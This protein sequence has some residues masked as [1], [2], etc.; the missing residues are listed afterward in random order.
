MIGKHEAE[1]LKC[2]S[3]EGI[4]DYMKTTLPSSTETD[5][6][7]IC[8]RALDMDIKSQL[9]LFEV[10]YQLLNEEMIDIRQN[11][12]RLEKQEIERKNLTNTIETL[13][14]ELT[15]AKEVIK[16]MKAALDES[17]GRNKELEMRISAV[18]SE[19][20]LLRLSLNDA[21]SET[22]GSQC[23]I[24]SPRSEEV[25][26]ILAHA[27]METSVEKSW[28]LVPSPDTV[29]VE[30]N[31]IVD[32]ILSPSDTGSELSEGDSGRGTVD[33][34]FVENGLAAD[35]DDKSKLKGARKRPE[36]PTSITTKKEETSDLS[37]SEQDLDS[38]DIAVKQ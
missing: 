37:S 31:R 20:D 13:R 35:T 28:E 18:Q 6:D 11:K 27:G 33:G 22:D 2:D 36:L 19:R 7:D 12:E 24:L 14:N 10:E 4:V 21:R 8:Q 5:T 15:E 16:M 30:M 9:H 32:G 26:A 3:F 25:Q 38:P 17:N 34:D 29:N 1:I 23:S